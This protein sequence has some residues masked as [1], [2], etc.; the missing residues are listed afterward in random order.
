MPQDDD[1]QPLRRESDKVDN[2]RTLKDLIDLQIKQSAKNE[3][4]FS[5][6]YTQMRI[7][8][9]NQ[10]LE[11]WAKQVQ[12]DKLLIQKELD[13]LSRRITNLLNLPSIMQKFRLSLTI[14]FLIILAISFAVYHY[15][16]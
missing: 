3:R 4:E 14:E 13:S 10:K 8:Q 6:N 9:I 15:Y 5:R 2:A 11:S 16:F 1:T 7:N 12:T